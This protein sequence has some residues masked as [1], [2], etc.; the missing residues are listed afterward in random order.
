[1]FFK[2]IKWIG[3]DTYVV[4]L[5]DQ[6]DRVRPQ[7]W[8]HNDITRDNAYKDEGST[9]EI[10]YLFYYFTLRF[11]QPMHQATLL[12]LYCSKNNPCTGWG[13]FVI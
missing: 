5:G 1:M 12:R 9:L 6:I 11:T 10:L 8:D 7:K 2:N 4:Q 13:H 3:K